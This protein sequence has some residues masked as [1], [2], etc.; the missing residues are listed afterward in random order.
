MLVPESIEQL[1]D[2][3]RSTEHVLVR[4]AGTKTALSRDATISTRKLSGILDYE[5]SEYTFTAL[6]GT[7]IADIQSVLAE[8]GQFLIFDP[9]LAEAGATLGGT[10]SA[11]LSGPG[12]FRFGGV[13]DFILGVRMVTGDAR[14]VFGGGKVVKNAAGFDIPKLVTGALG[15]M[16]VLVELTFK[17]FPAPETWT[18]IRADFTELAPTIDALHRLAVAQEDL[19]CLDL[20]P[21]HRL[22]VRLGG[23]AD[24]QPARVERVRRLIADATVE[25]LTGE[26]DARVWSD[27]REFRWLPE[28]HSL[29]KMPITS[30]QLPEVEAALSAFFDHLPCRYSVGG[31]V[32]WIGWPDSLE[33][34]ELNRLCQRLNRAIM[35]LTGKQSDVLR[36]PRGGLP[37]TQRLLNVFDPQSKFIRA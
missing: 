36:G 7:P 27:A 22:W 8:H 17:V 10:V 19:F 1:Q 28:E 6:A 9:P 3:V 4:G 13:R 16:G 31:N 21:P 34:T 11:G 18:T 29:I 5:P 24:A 20:E 30:G 32:A 35:I 33:S 15:R 14:V 37:F 23:L 2:A 12:R 25:L 26:D